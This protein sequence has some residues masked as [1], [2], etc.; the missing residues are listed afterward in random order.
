MHKSRRGGQRKS[1]RLQEKAA[2]TQTKERLWFEAVQEAGK[3][4]G[5]HA[6]QTEAYSFFYGVKR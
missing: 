4:A 1:L 2:E 5:G 6:A 3:A